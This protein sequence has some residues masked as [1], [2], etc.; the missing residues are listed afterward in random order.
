MGLDMYLYKINRKAKNDVELKEFLKL[1]RFEDEEF[2]A[3]K[4]YLEDNNKPAY[5]RTIFRQEFIEK[6]NDGDEE[7]IKYFDDHIATIEA[8]YKEKENNDPIYTC[9]VGY[10]RK[11]SDLHGYFTKIY[12]ERGGEESFNCEPLFLSKNE[13]LDVIEY[14]KQMIKSIEDGDDVEH[15]SGFFFGESAVSDWE[16]TIK[17][18]EKVIEEVDFDD[19][20]V[21]YDSWW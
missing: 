19:E 16:D 17:I 3:Y 10:W 2:N 6:Y 14:S 11:H 13:C 9:E 5:L 7:A 1:S 4:V 8:A 21:Y 18:F 20:S 12:E 15:T